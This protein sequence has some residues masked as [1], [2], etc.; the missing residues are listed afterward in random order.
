MVITSE[1]AQSQ[2]MQTLAYTA[3]GLL[4][5]VVCWALARVTPWAFVLCLPGTLMHEMAH[6]LAGLICAARPRGFSVW[7]RRIG[8]GR[9]Q[10]GRVDCRNITWWN[11]MFVALAPLATIALPLTMSWWRVTVEQRSVLAPDWQDISYWCAMA[12]LFCGIWPSVT[13]WRV[14]CRSWPIALGLILL[15][16]LMHYRQP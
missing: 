8:P 16:Y 15:A 13:D 6:Y 12:P 5:G 3:P 14:A 7:P 4:L 9:W 2:G 1:L 10:L 11:A